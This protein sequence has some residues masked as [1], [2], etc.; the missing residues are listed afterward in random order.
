MK[1]QL[2]V[3]CESLAKRLLAMAGTEDRPDAFLFASVIALALID[4]T[5]SEDSGHLDSAHRYIFGGRMKK[6]CE[7]IGV[8]Y[9][10]VVDRTSLIFK[11]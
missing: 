3:K 9:D 11:R 1:K 8:D 5:Y 4:M 7:L 10:F 6:H 2:T